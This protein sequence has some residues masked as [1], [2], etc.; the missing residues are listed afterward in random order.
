MR[1]TKGKHIFKNKHLFRGICLWTEMM[2]YSVACW[3]KATAL[4]INLCFNSSSF[5]W[6]FFQ[7]LLCTCSCTR[8]CACARAHLHC[9]LVRGRHGH[10]PRHHK[11]HHRHILRCVRLI[12]A[13]DGDEQL[14]SVVEQLLRVCGAGTER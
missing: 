4:S 8:V 6:P 11:L 12:D 13:E 3:V 14:D 2:K 7:V 5:A 9:F 1:M 10:D